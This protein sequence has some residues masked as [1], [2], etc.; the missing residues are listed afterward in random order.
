[1]PRAGGSSRTRPSHACSPRGFSR[2]SIDLRP[3]AAIVKAEPGSTDIEED[4]LTQATTPITTPRRAPAEREFI[5][6]L[7]DAARVTG[8]PSDLPDEIRA[9]LGG[10]QGRT[11]SEACALRDRQRVDSVL[12]TVLTGQDVQPTVADLAGADGAAIECTFRFQRLRGAEAKTAGV[13]VFGR[14]GAQ[15]PGVLSHLPAAILA[16]L[17]GLA[18]SLNL[19]SDLEALV[20]TVCEG[21]KILTQAESAAVFLRDRVTGLLRI[22]GHI[23]LPASLAGVAIH[24][25]EGAIGRVLSGGKAV[26]EPRPGEE[27]TDDDPVRVMNAASYILAPLTHEART[28]GVLA[29]FSREESAFDETAAQVLAGLADISAAAVMRALV[30]RDLDRLESTTQLILD[31]L[32]IGVVSVD[33][34]GRVLQANPEFLAL[35]AG[36]GENARMGRNLFSSELILQ[37]HLSPFLVDLVHGRAFEQDVAS[38]RLPGGRVAPMRVQGKP[39]RGEGGRRA[40]A[41]LIFCRGGGGNG[42]GGARRTVRVGF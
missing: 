30:R 6:L 9:A 28:V 14:V 24:E 12:K 25:G 32:P 4:R 42:A 31:E 40:G 10:R 36:P 41:V 13:L 29:V 33:S 5:V 18:K 3:R 19:V 11:F 39:L 17:M 26:W 2:R 23:G 35:I 22:A 34:E 37:N 7:D 38:F 16:R 1:M 8:L 20:A 27:L 21:A 15:A